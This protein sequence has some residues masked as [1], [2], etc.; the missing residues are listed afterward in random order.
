[1]PDLGLVHRVVTVLDPFGLH[2]LDTALLT[3]GRRREDFVAGTDTPLP[4]IVER[5]ALAAEAEGWLPDLLRAYLAQAPG[6]APLRALAA[7]VDER[8]RALAPSWQETDSPFAAWFVKKGGDFADR[9]VL[10]QHL[11]EI[12]RDAPGSSVLWLHGESGGGKSHTWFLLRQVAEHEG[13][14]PVYLDLARWPD[15]ITVA[16][17]KEELA[18]QLTP[19]V[20]DRFDDHAQPA[21]QAQQLLTGLAEVLRVRRRACWL[22]VDHLD[23]VAERE[24]IRWFVHE[25][26][27]VAAFE[28]SFLRILVAGWSQEELPPGILYEEEQVRPPTH[29]DI[30][31]LLLDVSARVRIALPPEV[32]DEAAQAVLSAPLPHR[33]VQLYRVAREQF[34]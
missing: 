4:R 34:E 29:D 2:D 25:L 31:A 19:E 24:E 9:A 1:M 21:R 5:I 3:V 12:A 23:R 8:D 28:S 27:R 15:R 33:A 10:R 20:A 18:R 32:V 17:L 7:E 6:N 26:M 14:D 13:C 16:Q 30:R 11:R 22:F